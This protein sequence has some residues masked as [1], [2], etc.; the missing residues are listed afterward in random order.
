MDDRDRR[1]T[2]RIEA[3][4]VTHGYTDVASTQREAGLKE[5]EFLNNQHSP[6]PPGTTMACRTWV[7]R[8]EA[9]DDLTSFEVVQNVYGQ[10]ITMYAYIACEQRRARPVN[11]LPPE[12]Y[13]K[14]PVGKPDNTTNKPAPRPA[15]GDTKDDKDNGPKNMDLEPPSKK[16]ARA[17]PPAWS[18]TEPNEGGGDCLP[19]ALASLVYCGKNKTPVTGA[20][21]RVS[22]V[23]ELQ[24]HKSSY[25]P[26]WDGN[27]PQREETKM[28]GGDFGAY[29]TA[30]ARHGAWL[31]ALEIGAFASRLKTVVIVYTT[32]A[33]PQ[34]FN[35][36]GS[37]V[38][39]LWYDAGHY[40]HMTG[41]PP[42]GAEDDMVNGP[43]IGMRGGAGFSNTRDI[44][45]T[46][47]QDEED[48][49]PE[50]F[51]RIFVK[52][53]TGDTITLDVEGCLTPSAV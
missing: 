28:E 50:Q 10:E 37:H 34:V 23:T 47:I 20:T 14:F 46:K 38:I 11:A 18:T 39:R 17:G 9:P 8:A 4:P 7:V 32:S 29:L 5:L 25:Q 45:K 48:R 1:R 24:K 26:F 22:I 6:K 49:S 3:V 13:T 33:P 40:E 27:K 53:L 41:T 44:A 52:T 19:L 30:I 16:C 43:A 35:R 36:K 31:G 42:K 15:S 2:W 12:R 51:S 21:V